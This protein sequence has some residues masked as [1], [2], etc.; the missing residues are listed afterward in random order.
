M[1]LKRVGLGGAYIIANLSEL[2]DCRKA[3]QDRICSM[4]GGMIDV[5]AMDVSARTFRTG[6]LW[7][8]IPLV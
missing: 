8:D 1:L 6:T 3:Q 2:S 4:I 5:L 7:S